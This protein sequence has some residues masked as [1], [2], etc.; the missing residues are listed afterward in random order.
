M[1]SFSMQLMKTRPL[2]ACAH[3]GFDVQA[4]ASSRRPRSNL[5]DDLSSFD[6]VLVER[7]LFLDVLGVVATVGDRLDHRIGDVSDAA[8]TGCL[9]GQVGR[10][11]INPHA[12]DHDRHELVLAKP[13]AEIIHTLH[14]CPY[15]N[16]PPCPHPPRRQFYAIVPQCVTSPG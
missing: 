16:Q 7:E 11:N 1:V 2:P 13:Q 6:V 9:Q 8:Q 12:A 14:L 10:R 5:T 15:G 4:V 3:G